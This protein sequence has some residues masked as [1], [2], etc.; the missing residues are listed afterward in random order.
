MKIYNCDTN[1]LIMFDFF[2]KELLTITILNN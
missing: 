2:T 1:F